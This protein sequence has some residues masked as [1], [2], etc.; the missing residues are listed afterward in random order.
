MGWKPQT[1]EWKEKFF[2]FWLAALKQSWEEQ[3][4]LG[5]DWFLLLLVKIGCLEVDEMTAV[6]PSGSGQETAVTLV[7]FL[8]V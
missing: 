2:V 6:F 8:N 5:S 7:A 1:V 3:A 4:N